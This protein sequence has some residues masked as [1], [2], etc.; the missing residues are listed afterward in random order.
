M[1]WPGRVHD[2]RVLSN[3]TL[4][5]QAQA[6][7]LLLDQ[8]CTL[9]GTSVHLVILGDPTYPLLPWLIKP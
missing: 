6:V 1:G 8:P 4:F 9:H 7:T 2:A 5:E 3:S